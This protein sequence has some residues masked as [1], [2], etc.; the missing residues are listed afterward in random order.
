MDLLDRFLGHDANTTRELLLRCRELTDEELDR[1]FDIGHG[2]L[3]ATFHHIIWNIEAWTD[4]MLARPRRDEPA[5]QFHTIPAMITR[6]D[7]IAAEFALLAR[8]V[9]SENRLDELFIDVIDDPPR[10]KT[11]G[12]AIV[13]TITH[14]MHHRAQILNIMRHLGMTNLIEGDAESWE[15]DRRPGGWPV[16]R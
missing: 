4:L 11:F 9:Q 13:H 12:A 1:R 6:L 8:R 16:A 5:A 10:R 7:A 14:S 2:S 3:R 15:R